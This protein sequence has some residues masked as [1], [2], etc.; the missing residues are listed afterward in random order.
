[1]IDED[2]RP[3][4]PTSERLKMAGDA[5]EFIVRNDI[6]E[7]GGT[8]SVTTYRMLDGSILDLLTKRQQ[9]GGAEYHAG[10]RFYSDWYLSGLA[11]SGVID[12]SKDIV[13]NSGGRAT[14]SDAKLAAMT[15]YH[16]AV[17]ALCTAHGMVMQCCVLA[18]EPLESYGRRVHRQNSPKRAR[19]AATTS[20]KEAL[21]ALDEHYNGRRRVR[22]GSSHADD[23]R[24]MGVKTGVIEIDG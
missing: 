21:T 4:R 3:V 10:V 17:K 11:N 23:Y 20:L 5:A 2:K 7:D 13:D 24:P 1:M 8:I 16:K 12:P 15:R 9:I 18:E 19:L 14:Q 22:M 6:D